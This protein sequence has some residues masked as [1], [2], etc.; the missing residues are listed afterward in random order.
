M[1]KYVTILFDGMAD[2]PDKSG[3]TPML[4]AYKPVTDAMAQKG[5]VGLC[6]T[7]PNGMKPGSDVANLSVM[8]YAPEIF[9]TGRSPL[10]ALSIG[11]EMGAEA[12]TYR[13][14]LVTLSNCEPYEE[15]TMV[16]YS[17]G[18]ITTEEA[19]TLIEFL[20]DYLPLG[21]NLKLY[22]G[23]SYRHCLLRK[24]GLTGATLVPPH[25]ISDKKITDYLPKAG[26]NEELLELMKLSNKLLSSHP[27]NLDRISRGLNP[28]NSIWFWGE[29]RK[30]ALEDFYK[31]HGKKGAVIS[32]VDLLKG[33]GKAA[34]MEVIEVNGATGNIDTNF[35]GKAQAAIDALSRNDYVYIHLEAPD[36][37]G[38]QGNYAS[39]K[40][41]IE[42]IDEK[43][44]APVKKFMDESGLSYKIAI[45]PDHATPV[46][47]KT[48]VSDP[49]P[50][51]IY[52]SENEVNGVPSL[53]EENA[54]KTGNNLDSGVALM[55][56]LFE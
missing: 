39:K 25:D 47:L 50:Y 32:A 28:A 54:S 36:E 44:V 6:K 48:H 46:T 24:A 5:L 56:K 53:T 55:K 34:G 18:E 37:C 35:D 27:V 21:D 2:Y 45:L 12:V 19:K 52:D 38:H 13:T 3:K 51:L 23:V 20:D 31:L 15:K 9:Y 40:R 16:D 26:Y 4:E 14:N 43:I 17:A 10:E 49:V 42:L 7:V 41:A 8:G 11:V 29:G 1:K 33:I 22:A 30:P